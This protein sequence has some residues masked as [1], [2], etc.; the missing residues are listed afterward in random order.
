MRMSPETQRVFPQD[1]LDYQ[2]FVR[3]HENTRQSNELKQFERFHGAR[4]LISQEMDTY[5]D[6]NLTTEKPAR[7]MKTD[8]CGV[9]NGNLT[10]I[11]C[12]S[13]GIDNSLERSIEIINQS[14]NASAIIL[15][16]RDTDQP[17]LT[18]P[19][20]EAITEGKATME[21]LGW[22]DDNLE[23]TFRETLGLIELLGNETRIRML[24]PLLEK[25]GAKKDYRTKINPKLVYHN[26]SALSEAGILDEN[27]EGT[28]ELSKF[29]KTVLAEFIT[30]LEKTRKTLDETRARR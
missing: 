5:L 2:T 3:R 23:T 17:G 4:R 20:K 11:F 14:Q 12:P 22:L 13:A 30:F 24:A 21:V 10:A 15:L 8:V 25:S 18:K 9:K 19:L 26:L 7:V 1:I 16:P 28:Y 6:A 27:T 29:G